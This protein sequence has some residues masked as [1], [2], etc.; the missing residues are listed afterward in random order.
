MKVLGIGECTLDH[1]GL[2]ERFLDPGMKVE[3]SKFSVQ[4][5]GAAATALVVLARWGVDTGFVGK[6][7][8]DPRGAQIEATLAE[9]G[10]ETSG[11][12]HE[13]AAI[14][15]FSFITLENRSG[16][17]KMQFTRGTVSALEPGE[18]DV[19]RL[20]DAELLLVDGIQPKAQIRAMREAQKR[21]VPVLLDASDM[22][23]SRADLVENSDY[24]MTSERF[25]SRFTGVGQLDAICESLLEVG[26]Q[27][28]AVTL[29]DEGVVAAEEGRG[30]LV[31]ESS[32]EVD[33][34]DTTG[35]GDIFAGAFAYGILQDW[36]LEQTTRAA[37]ITAG[38]SVSGMGARGSIPTLAEVRGH[39]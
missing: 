12:I 23:P 5:G 22:E 21:N 15:Q 34:T 37:N 19:G 25:A 33:V 11:L 18:I 14:S 35:S 9:E 3:M 29:G 32:H 30:G 1:F 16:E 39:F 24:L 17:R 6:V 2:V 38:I 4:G 26:P 20:D 36:S 31:R 8:D 28:V 27:T 13:D 10:V 7:G